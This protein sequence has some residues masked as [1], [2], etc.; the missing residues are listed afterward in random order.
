MIRI[1]SEMTPT[2]AK[3]FRQLCSMRFLLVSISENEEI[4]G[5]CWKTAVPYS[6]NNEL[7][8]EANKEVLFHV[9]HADEG[10]GF[11]GAGASDGRT[12]DYP[13]DVATIG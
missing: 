4:T 5:S 2:Y 9:G 10:C 3:A 8:N 7:M 6:K 1:L 13:S 12:S 11:D